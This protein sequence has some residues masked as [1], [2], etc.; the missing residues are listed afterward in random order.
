[1]PESSGLIEQLRSDDA[2]TRQSAAAA[3]TSMGEPARPG[4]PEIGPVA[5]S[6]PAATGGANPS[7]LALVHPQRPAAGEKTSDGIRLA[8][9]SNLRREIVAPWPCSRTEPACD[10]LSRLMGEEPSPAV[11]WTIV[12][13]LRQVGNLDG[14]RTLQRP[15]GQFT[16]AR[17]V[18]IRKTLGRI[19]RPRWMICANAPNWNSPIPADDDGEFD[20]VIRVLAD[21]ACQH[22]RYE[23][24]ADWRRRELARG[25]TSDGER[26]SD[27]AGGAF[28]PA[29][30]LRADQ[31]V[32]R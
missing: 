24:A 26:R 29:G 31:G 27:R 18:R 15:G 14:F 16:H 17:A 13:C 8:R 19:C 12:S 32:W 3:I 23:E 21:A 25:S 30:R 10:A 2:A 7:Q 9:T 22:K 4:D 1:M 20:F 5:G 11:Q 6:R 28:R